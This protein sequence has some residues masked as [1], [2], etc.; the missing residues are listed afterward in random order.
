[1]IPFFAVLTITVATTATNTL[2]TRT[3]SL[4]SKN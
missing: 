2:T 3:N 4:F 1:M